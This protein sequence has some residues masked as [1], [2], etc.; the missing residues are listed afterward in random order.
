M[1]KQQNRFAGTESLDQKRVTRRRRFS[2]EMEKAVPRRHLLLA[3]GP[4]YP[5]G[6]AG[7]VGRERTLRIYFL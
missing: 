6:G 3:I 4:Y 7:L 1:R 2:A 5:K